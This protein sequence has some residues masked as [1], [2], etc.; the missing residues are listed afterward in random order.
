MTL[1]PAVGTG[2]YKRMIDG[3]SHLW[4]VVANA[5]IRHAQLDCERSADY[6]LKQYGD[7]DPAPKLNKMG[8]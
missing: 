6:L 3:H 5:V 7:F 1:F 4:G 2:S 8:E